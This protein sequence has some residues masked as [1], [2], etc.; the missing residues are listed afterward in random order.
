MSH[1]DVQLSEA[2]RQGKSLVFERLEI[3]MKAWMISEIFRLCG[4]HVLVLTGEGLEESKLFENLDFFAHSTP[5]ELPSWETLPSE[6]LAP[7]SEVVGARQKAFQEICS[8]QGPRIILSSLQSSLQRVLS[9][10][11]MLEKSITLSQ[12]EEMLF[13]L[14]TEQLEL[15]GYERRSVVVEKGEFAVRGGIVD[16]F[17]V[18]EALPVR[19]EFFGDEIESI[20]SF[21][22]TSQ[23]SQEA[24]NQI[25]LS[26]A[27]ELELLEKEQQLL[28]VFDL[29]GDETIVILDDL[30]KLEDRYATLISQ[31]GELSKIFMDV[32]E[33]IGCIKRRQQV[34]FSYVP[35]EELS[36]VKSSARGGR[37]S[38]QAPVEPI[39][40]SIFDQ[41]F[42]IGRMA[43]PLCPVPELY[44]DICLL[45]HLP[46]GAELLE[47]FAQAQQ[48][49]RHTLVVQS[50]VELEWLKIK[51]NISD[52]TDVKEGQLSAGFARR[53]TNEVVFSTAEVTG[54][55]TVRRSSRQINS[56]VTQYDAFE[57]EKGDY[58]VH[59][60]HGFGRYCG[61]EEKKDV[62]G[63][64]QEFFVVEYAERSRLFVPLNQAHLLSKYVG[65]REESPKLHVLGASKWK[66]LREDTERA[67]LGYASDLL[68]LQANRVIRGGFA[69]SKDGMNMKLFEAEFP[70]TE[71]QDQLS[72]IADIKNDMC[73]EKAM[74]RLVCGDVGYGKTE[75]AMRAAFKTVADGK[76]Q[77]AIV[78]PT[79][80]LAVQHYDNF[81]ERMHAFGIRLGVLS[82]FS[83]PKQ[84]RETIEK[85]KKGEIDIVI[86]THR[87]VQ[88]DVEFSD[89]GMVIVDEEQ[90]FG[91][92]TKEQ[93]KVLKET[94]DFL[95]LS[96]TPIPR[97]LYMSLIGV[98]ELSTINTPPQERLPTK[99]VVC[100]S[101]DGLIQT[102][103]LRELNRGGQ[104]F[105]VHNRV[106]TIFSAASR[107]QKLVPKAKIAVAHGQMDS[108][109]LD[110]VFHAFKRGEVDILVA[111]SI[112]ENGIDIPNANTMIVDRADM[113]GIAD[114]YQLRG[115]VGRWNR[116]AY[117]YFLVPAKRILSEVSRKRLEAI[118][119]AGGYGGGL[120]VAMRD[121]EIRGAG[122]ILGTEQS[123]HVCAIGFHLYCKLLKRT[124]DSLQGKSSSWTIDTKLETPFDAKLPEYYVNEISL[125]IEFYQRLGD[126][127]SHEEVDA[128]GKEIRDR[129]GVL[130]DQAS[131]LLACTRVRIRAAAK[132]FSLVKV[133]NYS[134]QLERK[135]GKESRTNRVLMN[136]AKTPEEFEMKMI[137]LFEDN[138]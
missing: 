81:S 16:I 22:P 74:D 105:F 109:E 106:E 32:R 6:G 138:A 82:R 136:L 94:V 117:A 83:T 50:L 51:T 132:G 127:K 100:E 53:D 28:S 7:S 8:S 75:V 36:Q 87:L 121:L 68:R 5:V 119:Q 124:I 90:R 38:A 92:K 11:S 130:P 41:Q 69:Y 104:A 88:K 21:D 103:L 65:G 43:H 135:T 125:R 131:W 89:L 113:F 78:A 54:R 1:F 91:V 67:I 14:L 44:E 12:G 84:N 107:I 126:A 34:M 49:A 123:G 80:V 129:F 20:R 101:D 95:T 114:L 79:T 26:P 111:T 116:R 76:K 30:E 72:A 4:K 57:L 47:L 93:L 10:E 2:I 110:K 31:G 133:E 71:T 58:V 33:W 46:Q 27:K 3:P 64:I 102:A 24:L 86:G 56:V 137:Q 128:I 96:A 63:R 18:T 39:E 98:R 97:T 112:I 25:A 108:D 66:K 77:V 73:S 13:D 23:S 70:Y 60:H 52:E 120:K 48:S 59:F 55:S 19:F 85:V 115:R 134:V 35:I 9:S 118:A 45:D 99:S 122:D 37:Y 17:P 42:A 15:M 61:V 40:F 62:Q 29:L